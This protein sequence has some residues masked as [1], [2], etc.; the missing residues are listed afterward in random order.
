MKPSLRAAILRAAIE[1]NKKWEERM[2]VLP[3]GALRV[4][5]PPTDDEVAA[6]IERY[7]EEAQ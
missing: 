7:M 1:I 6:I 2:E 3:P 5:H 4:I